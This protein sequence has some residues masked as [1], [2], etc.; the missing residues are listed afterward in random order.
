MVVDIDHIRYLTGFTG[1]NAVLAI[2]SGEAFFVTDQRYALQAP[3]E[4]E[5]ASILIS[6]SGTPLLDRLLSGPAAPV[7]PRDLA[8]PPES[9]T[10]ADFDHL[11]SLLPARTTPIALPG[12]VAQVKAI[13]EPVEVAAIRAACRLADDGCAFLAEHIRAGVTERCVAWELECF[14]RTRGARR[15]AFDTIVASGPNAA[16]VHAR[17]GE[18]TIGCSG[19]AEF[20]L[21]DFGCEVDGYCSD[22]TRTFVVGGTPDERMCDMYSAVEEARAAAVA[23][24]APGVEGKSVDEVARAVLERRGMPR[25]PHNTGHGLG[26]L[27]HDAS[28][29]F[30]P[31]STLVLQSGM[32]VTVEPGVYCEGFGGVRIEDDVLLVEHGAECLTAFPRGMMVLG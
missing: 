19:S 24:A 11:I 21:V 30:T 8:F 15:L 13:K 16:I 4:V 31:T 10:V 23:L 6:P 17:A 3:R 12:I 14:L 28:G 7:A 1:S 9:L 5:C 26:R 18:R 27:V 32:V 22:I 29:V 2:D 25:M 20:V